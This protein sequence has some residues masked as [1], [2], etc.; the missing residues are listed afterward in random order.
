MKIGFHLSIEGG[1]YRSIDRAIILGCNVFQIFTRNPRAW[2]SRKLKDD[3]VTIFKEKLAGTLI[4]NVYSH[5]PYILNLSSPDERIFKKSVESLK[6]ELHRCELLGISYIVTHL[7]SHLGMGGDKAIE[8][9]AGVLREINISEYKGINIL[10]ENTAGSLNQIG[11]NFSDLQKIIMKVDDQRI[12]VCFDTCHAYA[13]GMNLKTEKGLDDTLI[14]IESTIGFE[15]I[16]LIHLNDCAGELG[17]HYDRHEH[18]GLGKIEEEG[19][20]RI[21]R[22]KLA[23]YPLVMETPVDDR[24]GDKENMQVVKRLSS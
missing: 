11:S 10:L 20:K 4:E 22:S 3:E 15:N 23:G 21:L 5:M 18:I 16:K 9:I 7:G 1:I 8:Q 17:S 2:L 14:E 19:F 13:A 24:R 12:G 6:T